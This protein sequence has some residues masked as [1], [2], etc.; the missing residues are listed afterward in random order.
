MVVS[1]IETKGLIVPTEVNRRSM[2]QGTRIDPVVEVRLERLSGTILMSHDGKDHMVEN[3][4]DIV[5]GGKG[6]A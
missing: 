4:R 6:T 1:L 3:R 2:E 5:W